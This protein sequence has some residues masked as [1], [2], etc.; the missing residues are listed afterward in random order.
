M[1]ASMTYED[2]M[3]I[4]DLAQE[5]DIAP[6][7][8]R[9]EASL[10]GLVEEIGELIGALDNLALAGPGGTAERVREELLDV[11]WYGIRFAVTSTSDTIPSVVVA[12]VA[13][14]Y[15]AAAVNS[16]P[17][18][19]WLTDELF[20]AAGKIKRAAR[21]DRPDGWRASARAIGRLMWVAENAA[22]VGPMRDGIDA[23]EAR[24]RS[25][26]ERGVIA[27]AGGGR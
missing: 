6:E 1:N 13:E 23:L 24:L 3:R 20:V 25:R 17:R 4:A 16:E 2:W 21:G 5:T 18:L 11:G 15:D 26:L 14:G 27:G 22:C 9:A 8:R 10:A 12:K 19:P 7:G